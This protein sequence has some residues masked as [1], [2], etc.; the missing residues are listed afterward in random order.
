MVE[1]HQRVTIFDICRAAGVSSATVSRVI[2]DSPLVHET[3][4]RRVRK[5]IKK[6][7]YQPSHAARMLMRQRTD[8]IA[9]IFPEI[10]SPFY[11]ELLAGIDQAAEESHYHILTAF[12]HR[13][14][15]AQELVLRFVQ[16]RRVDAAIYLNMQSNLTGTVK[17]VL[18]SGL[19][20]V[21]LDRFMDK[22]PCVTIDNLTG[23][24]LAVE[25]LLACGH[26]RIAF[27]QGPI[28]NF[29]AAQR[30]AGVRAALNRAGVPL[31]PCLN[32]PGDFSE[33]GGVAAVKAWAASGRPW[34]DAILTCND[35]MAFGV[36][37]ALREMGVKVP[38]Q[39]A[40]MGFDDAQ[41]ARWLGLT[42]IR[43]PRR[44]LGIHAAHMAL[45]LARGEKPDPFAI[46][47]SVQLVVR[48]T[49]GRIAG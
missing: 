14:R 4:R 28:D 44:E 27:Q 10:E 5:I 25:H 45:S 15:M 26:R 2:N 46:C 22:V 1:L 11:A 13:G 35:T 33:E 24:R 8:T 36:L 17:N 41:G 49:C 16:E 43:V 19:P 42:T 6:L 3:T 32:W 29:D 21:L 9:V 31:E 20:L 37:M 48:Q 18:R 12:V 38:G 34:P 40:V 39:V 47:L 30:L 7:G 23:A